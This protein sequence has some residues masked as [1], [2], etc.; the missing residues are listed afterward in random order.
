MPPFFFISAK[1]NPWCP[2]SWYLEVQDKIPFCQAVAAA[3]TTGSQDHLNLWE[4][5]R[6]KRQFFVGHYIGCHFNQKKESQAVSLKGRSSSSTRRGWLVWRPSFSC[7]WVHHQGIKKEQLPY[8]KRTSKEVSGITVHVVFPYESYFATTYSCLKNVLRIWAISNYMS[9]PNNFKQNMLA[10]SSI[11]GKSLS[12][13][14]L[15]RWRKTEILRRPS[16]TYVKPP[17][18][19]TKAPVVCGKLA[20]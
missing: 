20:L 4:F 6:E 17:E 10:F 9:N 14:N 7:Q 19:Q 18:K 5:G 1:C 16:W 15:R 2:L 11:Y 3:A 12:I 13:S 8:L